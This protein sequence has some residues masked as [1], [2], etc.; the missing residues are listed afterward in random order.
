MLRKFRFS[1]SV[2]LPQP[3]AIFE[4]IDKLERVILTE[5]YSC[6]FCISTIHGSHP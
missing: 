6:V 1:L 2:V 5:N 4:G 3:S